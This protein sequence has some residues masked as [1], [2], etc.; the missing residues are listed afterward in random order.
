LALDQ[1]PA[2]APVFLTEAIS[3]A[4][5]AASEFSDP[6]PQPE[7]LLWPNFGCD[8]RFLYP[9]AGRYDRDVSA[10]SLHIGYSKRNLVVSV[11]DYTFYIG[12]TPT[13]ITTGSCD[14]RRL[15][16]QSPTQSAGVE[17]IATFNP[18]ALANQLW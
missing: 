6:K 7:F 18:G 3:D 10:L 5:R 12:D 16:R 8:E 13:I 14:F 2:T 15:V 4:D 11:R 9:V 17:G 1:L